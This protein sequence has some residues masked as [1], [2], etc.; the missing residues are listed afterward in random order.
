MRSER[1]R[2]SEIRPTGLAQLCDACRS[3]YACRHVRIPT[4]PTQSSQPMHTRLGFLVGLGLAAPDALAAQGPPRDTV[5]SLPSV[6]VT[7]NRAV[8][9]I[10]TTPL[11]ITKITAPALR[12]TNGYG[13][14]DAL[15]LV[16]GVVAQ[17]GYGTSDIRIM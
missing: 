10:L 9:P 16:P 15:S 11:A 7:A 1:P 12:S 14:E 4:P 6:T 3:L 2:M 5:V 17:S 8:A 13:L